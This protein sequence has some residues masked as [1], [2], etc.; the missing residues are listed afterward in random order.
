M[1]TKTIKQI[2]KE[3]NLIEKEEIKVE[4]KPIEKQVETIYKH[5]KKGYKIY[6]KYPNGEE[7]LLKYDKKGN[8]I[9]Y[10]DYD[11]DEWFYKYDNKG[12]I[13]YCKYS[14]YSNSKEWFHE[15]GNIL[16]KINNIWYLNGKRLEV[17]K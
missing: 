11:G 9:Y 17:K 2:M 4:L 8:M 14:E 6:E 16:K 7:Y 12:H 15:G 10:K 13:I 5:D 1:K 3:N